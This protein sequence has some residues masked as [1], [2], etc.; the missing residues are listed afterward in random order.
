MLRRA[1][2]LAIL[3]SSPAW[4]GT[5]T[6]KAPPKT[7][8]AKPSGHIVP[9]PATPKP[10]GHKP[11]AHPP[12]PAPKPAPPAAPAPQ[13]APALPAAPAE[14]AKGT[15]TGLPLP[16]FASFK[17]DDVNLRSGPGTR[18]PIEWV[19][20]RRDLPVEIEREFE[21]WRL[22]E[23]S[24]GVKG[25]VHQATL[26]GRRSFVVTGGE[27]VMRA[28]AND[29]AS[30]VARLKPG[31]VGRLRACDAKSDW[32]QVQVGDYRGWLRRNEFWGAL[33]GEAVQ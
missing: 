28:E 18:Y 12:P 24:E 30:P 32:C 21:V 20:K 23:D 6:T 11:A 31:V 33:P 19:Y 27:Q 17:T 9:K 16:R 4:A 29:K 13:P 3:L 14:P 1:L 7:E 8:A 15:N 10:T 2:L 5:E 22:V 26:T 25:W